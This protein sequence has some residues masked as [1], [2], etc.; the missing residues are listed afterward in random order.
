[1]MWMSNGMTDRPTVLPTDSAMV[2]WHHKGEILGTHHHFIVYALEY[3]R[4]DNALKQAVAG[5][6]DLE[7]LRTDNDIDRRIPAEALVHALER[8]AAEL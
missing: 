6:D 2:E 4:L 8:A 5:V 1:M 3:D 7:I